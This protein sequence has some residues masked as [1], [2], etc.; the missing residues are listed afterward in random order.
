MQPEQLEIVDFLRRYQPFSHLDEETLQRVASNIEISYFKA[1]TP[2]LEFGQ[3]VDAWY[4]IRS[5]AVEVYRRNGELYN[6][7]SEGGFFGEF[8][9]L[10]HGLTRFPA[11]ALED[12]LAYLIPSPLFN[13][14]FEQNEL[15]A[16]F[17]EVEDRTRLR[18]TMA[19]SE[20]AN[21]LMTSQVDTL[22]SRDPVTLDTSASA[23]QAAARMSEEGVSSLLILHPKDSVE[24]NDD[25]DRPGAIMAGLITDRDLRNRLLA[26]G[27]DYNTPVSDIMTTDVIY[28]EHNQ[29][30]FE[31]MLVMLRHNVHHL[32][33]FRH[34]QLIGV[35][36]LSDI[37][38]YESQ[39]SLFVVGSI[40]RANSVEELKALAGDVRACFTRMVNEDANSRMI[41][42]AMAV[43]GRS[44]KQRLL[45]LAEDKLGPPPVPYCFLALG[46]M[47][48]QEQLIVTDQDNAM[49]LDN[50][51]DPKQHDPYFR[52]LA[53]FVCD[54]L[55]E[56]GYTYCKGGIMATNPKWR[57]PL[58]VWEG[59]FNEWINNPTPQT[60]LNSFIFFD[61]DGVWGKTEWAKRLRTLIV[62]KSQ[63]N[64]RFLACMARNALLRKPPLGFFKDFVM[65]ASGQHTRSINMKRRGTAPLAD[66][67]RVHALA[68]GSRSRNSFDRLQDI[69]EA[70]ILPHGRGQDLRDALEFISTVRIRHQALDLAAGHEPDNNIE[71]ENLSDFERKNLKDAFQI[72]SNAQ[73]FLKYRYQ[74]GRVH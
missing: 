3:K 44:F 25:I 69:I 37:I 61:L 36:A 53:E 11:T 41:G 13:E 8:G 43:I 15:F 21:E 27:L 64:S 47:A 71:P 6:R 67:I 58:H 10:R 19:R 42:S 2:I 68:V 59:Y 57:Q 66:L 35:I 26:Q 20:D 60:L 7:L 56:C 48:R 34:H 24:Q 46:S 1:G 23:Q 72:L 33:V 49:I 12:T 32:P 74:P 18:Q 16:D 73:K 52:A 5:G 50:R 40:F 54:G 17:V 4:V 31:A 51:Y 65:E 45:E 30:I 14:L 55:D 28:A 9:L 22:I 62:K 39:N 70:D 63:R 38:R 29:L